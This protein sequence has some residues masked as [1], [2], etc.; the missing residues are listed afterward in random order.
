MMTAV[1]VFKLGLHIKQIQQ[2]KQLAVD[3]GLAPLGTTM[4]QWIVLRN[5]AA[6]PGKSAHELAQ[7]TFQTDQSF[8]ALVSRLV[9]RGLVE[10]AQGPGRRLLHRL[11]DDG[12]ALLK[13]CDPLVE[14]ALRDQFGNLD[15]TELGQLHALLERIVARPPSS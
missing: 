15:D 4:S 5:I 11:T 7:V 10:R 9:D 2:R 12:A 6:H 8:G 13:R 14:R 3:A 1:D